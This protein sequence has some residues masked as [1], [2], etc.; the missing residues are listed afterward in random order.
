MKMPIALVLAGG[1]GTR[2]SPLVTNKTMFPFQG[3]PMIAHVL[4]LLENSD[5]EQ[6]VV[7]ANQDNLDWLKSYNS[8]K[9]KVT[10]VLQA[11]ATGMADAVLTLK[12]QLKDQSV[13]IMNGVDLVDPSFVSQLLKQIK[14]ETRALVAGIEM[15]RY[16]PGGYF[17]LDQA[18]RVI[19]IVE[20]PE[21]GTQPSN[22]VNLVF[23]YFADSSPFFDLLSRTNSNQDDVYERALSEFMHQNQ[24]DVFKYTGSWNKLKYPHFVLDISRQL[25]NQLDQPVI[26]NSAQVHSSAIIEGNVV[27]DEGVKVHEYAVVKGPSYIGKNTIVGNHSLVLQSNI[28]A[29]SV[30]GAHSEVT[31]SYL[32]PKT[33]LHHNFVGDS[34][35]E[36]WSNPSYGTC[37]A[38]MRL[39]KASI[40]L[41]L[42]SGTVDTHR[43][44]LGSVVARG[45]FSGVNCSFMPGTVIPP[46][47]K[48]MPQTLVSGYWHGK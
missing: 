9:L 22:L 38:N 46:E 48:I 17:K 5:I 44:K 42:E 6:A 34:V 25:L 4:A 12:N 19:D 14:P 36:G 10:P 23:H 30:I 1:Q 20:K 39:D 41:K 47:T 28:E 32:G 26:A 31:R 33:L 13:L 18:G 8:N 43:Q 3:R 2:F 15:D 40:K 7:T 37:F 27:I 24:V 45:L 29:D 35:I 16:F 21:P 11:E